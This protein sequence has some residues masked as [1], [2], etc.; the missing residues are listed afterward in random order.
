MCL[1][2]FLFE[3]Y[4]NVHLIRY[5]SIYIYVSCLICGLSIPHYYYYICLF[6]FVLCIQCEMFCLFFVCILVGSLIISSGR[7]Y[8][9]IFV[10]L[11]VLV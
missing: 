11:C 8:F 3:Y 9:V 1:G 4:Y 5:G 2:I 7:C 10:C 6:V